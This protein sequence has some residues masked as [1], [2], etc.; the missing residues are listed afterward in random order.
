M[1]KTSTCGLLGVSR[2]V[3]YRSFRSMKQQGT[4]EQ[5]VSIIYIGGRGRNCYLALVTDAYSK[6]I[7]VY[8]ASYSL[9]TEGSLIALNMAIKL[10][11]YRNKLIHHPDRGLLYCSNDY[12]VTLKKKKIT[13][14]MTE[15]YIPAT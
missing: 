10:R 9:A 13:P 8:D 2:Q 15:N 6:K 12:Q 7:M 14:S 1:S 11:R 3:Y 4:A 5:V